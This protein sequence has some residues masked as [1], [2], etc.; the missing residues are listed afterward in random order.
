MASM[1]VRSIVIATQILKRG[2]LARKVENQSLG[3][4]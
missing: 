3:E 1:H 2:E 4:P